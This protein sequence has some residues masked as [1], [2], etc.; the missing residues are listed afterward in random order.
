MRIQYPNN[1]QEKEIMVDFS[2]I[3]TFSWKVLKSGKSCALGRRF[4]FGNQKK[5]EEIIVIIKLNNK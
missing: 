2:T 4:G 3:P 5:R 1:D